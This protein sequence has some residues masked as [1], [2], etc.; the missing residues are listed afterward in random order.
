MIPSANQ[1]FRFSRPALALILASSLLAVILA[2]TTVR[3]LNR[4]QRLLE[5]FFFQE[6]LT[7]IRSFEA[8]A[9]TSMRHYMTGTNP[10]NTLVEETA[11]EESVAYIRILHETGEP[12]AESGDLPPAMGAED[13]Q[14][15]LSA[16][17]PVTRLLKIEG[18]SIFEVAR[19]FE[20][21]PPLLPRGGRMH[22]YAQKWQEEEEKKGQQLIVVGLG[23]SEF[24]GAREKD[25]V[26][27]LFMGAVL[28]LLGSAG[29]YFLFLYQSIRVGNS[30]LANM[31]LYTE[32]VIESIPAGLITLN[33]Q[34]TVVSCN[35]RAEM[36]LCRGLQELQGMA[37]GDL[38]SSLPSGLLEEQKLFMEKNVL[39]HD[40]NGE[41]IPV[42]LSTSPLL[43]HDGQSNGLVIVLRDMREIQKIEQQLE[44]SRRL[45]SLGKMAAGVAHEIRNP[46]GTLRGF[47]QYFGNE[48]GEGTDGKK[49][50][51]LMV[52]EVDRLNQ[53]ISSLLQFARAREPQRMQVRAVD[54]FGKLESLV[55]ADFV[56]ANI[57][58]YQDY[59]S[60]L[61]LFADPDLLLQVLLNLVKNSISVTAAGGEIHL[62]ARRQGQGVQVEVSDTGQG[63]TEEELEKL[64][65]P[66]FSTRKDGTGLGLAV[67]HQIVEQHNGY[68][69][70]ESKRGQGTTMKVILPGEN[71][72]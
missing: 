20:P 30:T 46:L 38:F 71:S 59:D 40:S 9:R 35:R 1:P 7:L 43:D 13:V 56:A 3:N 45:A 5:T 52:S 58:Y 72:D 62:T 19:V 63:M 31:R 4:E 60:G 29:L 23:T 57:T 69:E 37:L 53:T 49:Y 22:K 61:F 28:F 15:I 2:V 39:C 55:A 65:D 6:G 8:G 54:L 68:I 26:N 42:K 41:T 10:L 34:G 24:E 51:E 67:S 44:L 12:V 25:R 50:A 16:Q 17:E 33:G 47:A 11:K 18:K 14:R 66:F 48:A 64:F 36:L 21:L 27:A 70:V 32:N